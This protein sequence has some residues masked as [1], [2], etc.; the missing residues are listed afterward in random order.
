VV[1]CWMGSRSYRQ[2]MT[3]NRCVAAVAAAQL[4]D[5]RRHLGQGAPYGLLEGDVSE[6]LGS[7]ELLDEGGDT[8][9]GRDVR[10]VYLGEVAAED[11][12]RVAAHPGEYHLECG[13]LQV[14]C[15]V[16]DDEL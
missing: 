1:L 2:L 5:V 10:V 12:L 4:Q 14:L 11:H 7:L 6:Q 13:E 8:A 3:G 15:L 16:D 9:V